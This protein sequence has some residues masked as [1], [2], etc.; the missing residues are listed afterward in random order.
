M[1]DR[2]TEVNHPASGITSFTYDL[3]MVAQK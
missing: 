1:G 3:Q 2:R